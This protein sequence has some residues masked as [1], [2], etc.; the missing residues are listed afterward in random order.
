MERDMSQKQV[1]TNSIDS[2]KHVVLQQLMS[3]VKA[4]RS[5][6]P[7]KLPKDG[8]VRTIRKTLGMS[9]AQLARKMGY[10]RNR[11]SVLEKKE[12]TGDISINQLRELANGLNA[13]LTYYIVPQKDPEQLIKDQAQKKATEIIQNT[14][15]NMYLELQQ[16]D[17]KAL[18][19]QIR[20]LADE[21]QRKGGKA[22]WG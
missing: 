4:T 15:Q 8:W 9:G 17:Q 16:I 18:K 7:P 1:N 12:A 10:T 5:L 6:H 19:E 20:F 22:L 14:H 13:D 21:I 11:I 2:T 3:R